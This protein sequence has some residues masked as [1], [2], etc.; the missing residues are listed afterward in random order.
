MFQQKTNHNKIIDWLTPKIPKKRQL[1]VLEFHW[2]K[3]NDNDHKLVDLEMLSIQWIKNV[4]KA[5]YFSENNI[6][7]QKYLNN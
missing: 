6:K 5:L 3:Y 7:K 2:D 4:N 1:I